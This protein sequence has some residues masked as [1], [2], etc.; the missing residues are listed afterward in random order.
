MALKDNYYTVSQVAQELNVTRQT[1]YRWIKNG[2]L[3]GE[4]IGRETLVEKSEVFRYK[5]EKVGNWLYEIFNIT[6][7]R[8]KYKIIREQLGYDDTDVIERMGDYTSLNYIVFRKGKDAEIVSI[9]KIGVNINGKNGHLESSIDP[10]DITREPAKD[11]AK[12]KDV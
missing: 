7:E 6:L 5:D 11:V 12:R 9:K 2:N 4:K 3:K 1:I 8:T 10:N